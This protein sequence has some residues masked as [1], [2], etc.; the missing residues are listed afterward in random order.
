MAP[1]AACPR[2]T[3]VARTQIRNYLLGHMEL[4]ISDSTG[5]PP[6]FIKP[7][8]FE[9]ETHGF[10]WKSLLGASQQHNADFRALWAKQ[11][12]RKLPFRY[13][14]KDSKGSFHLVVT[15]K[16]QRPPAP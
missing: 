13:G 2:T 15:R 9:Q 3:A 4:M 8:G 1:S 11:P 10:F 16:I 7:A 5:I 14:Y 12:L 6:A